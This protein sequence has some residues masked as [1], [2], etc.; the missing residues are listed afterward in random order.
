MS[1]IY[2]ECYSKLLPVHNSNNS[3]HLSTVCVHLINFVYKVRKVMFK[4]RLMP[5]AS[6]TGIQ[7]INS[8][9]ISDRYQALA[10]MQSPGISIRTEKDRYVH[11]YALLSSNRFIQFEKLRN[12]HSIHNHYKMYSL[13][14]TVRITEFFHA[15]CVLLLQNH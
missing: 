10:D 9:F 7:F 8:T 12:I 11:P 5:S 1:P 3:V 14:Q 15:L 4:S 2:I 13:T 6:S